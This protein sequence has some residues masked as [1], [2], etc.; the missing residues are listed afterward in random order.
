[1]IFVNQE[2]QG[3][4]PESSPQ[5][6]SPIFSFGDLWPFSAGNIELAELVF[7]SANQCPGTATR[8]SAASARQLLYKSG[9]VC[10]DMHVQPTP[11]LESVVLIGQ[12]LDSKP[13]RRAMKDIPVSLLCGGLAISH[14]KTNHVGEF[15]FGLGQRHHL[16]LVIGV[17]N[18]RMLV[19]P[20]PE[21]SD[22]EQAHP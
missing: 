7:D 10:I 6:A 19:V 9:S 2:V 16:Q 11:G 17:G 12:L 21:M 15:D 13:P 1:M 20:V 5:V 18:R 3:A 22:P 8:A 14:K 4:P